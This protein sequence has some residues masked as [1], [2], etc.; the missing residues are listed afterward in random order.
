M[1]ISIL[2]GAFNPPTIAVSEIVKAVLA[3]GA[4]DEVWL[5]PYNTRA[6]GKAVEVSAAQ[7]LTMTLLAAEEMGPMVKVSTLEIEAKGISYTSETLRLLAQKYSQHQF[8]WIIGADLLPELGRWK[9]IDQLVEEERF[10]CVQRF[11]FEADGELLKQYR[12]RAVVPLAKSIAVSSSEVRERIR[13]E[14]TIRDLVPLAVERYIEE[15][16]LYLS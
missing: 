16:K 9:E 14:K 8:N 13:E 6:F 7:R 3:I 12:V 4:A 11:G 2:G 1:R 5:M 10:L 15:N